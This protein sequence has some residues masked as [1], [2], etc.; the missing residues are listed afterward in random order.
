MIKPATQD[1]IKEM[2]KHKMTIQ[3]IANTLGLSKNSVK[4]VLRGKHAEPKAKISKYHQHLP[5]IRELFAF[6]CGNAVRVGE[7]L[8]EQYRIDIPYSSLRW[9]INQEGLGKPAKKPAGSYHFAPGEEMQHDTSPY[10]IILGNKPKTAQC[11]SLALAYKIGR[12]H[13]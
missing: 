11:A 3:T 12:A 7:V 10:K 1:A 8:N 9:L 2:R 5:I 6:C 13:V 4:S